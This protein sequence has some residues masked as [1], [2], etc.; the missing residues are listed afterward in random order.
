MSEYATIREELTK[1]VAGLKKAGVSG[2]P[3]KMD[4]FAEKIKSETFNLVVLG[5]FKR[6]KSTF[7][8]A[9]LGEKVLPTSI[10]PL[11]SVVTILRYGEKAGA[12]V[13]F[14]DGKSIDI[15]LSEIQ[16]YV[17]EKENPENRLKVR[18]VEVF[19]PSDYLKEGVRIVDTPGVG[20]VFSHNT[21]VAYAYLPNADAGIFVVTPDPPMGESEHKFLNEIG[22][23]LDKLFFVLNKIDQVSADDLAEAMEFTAKL[24][25]NDLKGDVVIHPISAAKALEGKKTDNTDMFE[26]SGLPE[27]EVELSRFLVREKGKFFL[28]SIISGLI[29]KISDETMSCRLEQEAA[30]LSV[31]ELKSKI[32]T[33]EQYATDTRKDRE[34]QGFILEGRVKNLAAKIDADLGRLKKEDLPALLKNLEAVFSERINSRTSAHDL[35]KNLEEFVFA[36]IRD[37]FSRF[38]LTEADAVALELESI[39]IDIA[40]RTNRIIEKIINMTADLFAVELSPFTTIEKLSAKSDFYFL[41]KDDPGAIELIRLSVAHALPA[42]LAKGRILKRLKATVAERFERHCGRVR[43]DLIRRIDDTTRKFKTTLN[44]KIELTLE[45]IRQALNRAVDIKDKSELEMDETLA[46][47]TSRISEISSIRN[48][49]SELKKRADR[50]GDGTSPQYQ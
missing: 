36:G 50:L 39:Y 12:R 49:L 40:G 3:E 5:E 10:V 21:D 18:E 13:D 37:V 45:T 22:E 47:L 20:S 14:L 35:E 15:K 4:T 29:K 28:K 27:F 30:R 23:H 11:T 2:G 9:L 38:R 48:D 17:T 42:V 32:A 25:E 44:N 16:K 7:I 31:D 41:L 19:Y 34:Q 33:F 43:Y 26:Q 24:L 46:A 6:G 1:I 8:N